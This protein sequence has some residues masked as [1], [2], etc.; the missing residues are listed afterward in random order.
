MLWGTIAENNIESCSS[1]VLEKTYIVCSRL[2]T[3]Q[4][5]VFK[6]S[7]NVIKTFALIRTTV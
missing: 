5:N 3:S 1:V 2:R 7:P 6:V 4:T